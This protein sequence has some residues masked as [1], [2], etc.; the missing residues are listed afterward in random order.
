MHCAASKLTKIVTWLYEIFPFFLF[1]LGRSQ[2]IT[3]N[4]S[5]WP[6]GSAKVIFNLQK[7]FNFDFDS[8]NLTNRDSWGLMHYDYY[9]GQHSKDYC[10]DLL[11]CNIVSR[12]SCQI[13]I[14]LLHIKSTFMYERAHILSQTSSLMTKLN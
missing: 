4:L 11:Y 7:H 6:L 5:F 8:L 14:L 1:N 13:F 2:K 12:G 3:D 10:F 9:V